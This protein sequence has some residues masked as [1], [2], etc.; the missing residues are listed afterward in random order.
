MPP[1]PP[2]HFDLDGFE[3][4]ADTGRSRLLRVRGRWGCPDERQLPEPTLLVHHGSRVARLT[5]LPIGGDAPPQ[6][7]P[8]PPGWAATYSVPK[9]IFAT[10]APLVYELQVVPDVYHP[11]PLPATEPAPSGPEEQRPERPGVTLAT[12]AGDVTVDVPQATVAGTLVAAGA[13]IIATAVAITLLRSLNTRPE[14]LPIMLVAIST[15]LIMLW[16][17]AWIVPAFAALTWTSIEQSQFG[18]VSPIEI[19]GLVLL[20]VA[21]L[22]GLRRPALLANAL[23]VCLFI[24]LPLLI[25]AL[26]SPDGFSMPTDA[27]KNLSFLLI[28][29]LGMQ[30]RKD[31]DRLTIALCLVAIF[32]GVGAASSVLLGPSGIF[33]VETDAAG[34]EAVRAAGPFGESNFFAL[35]LAA[36]LPVAI[37]NVSRVGW[38][39]SLGL[40][41]AAAILAGIFAAGSRGGFLT[42]GFAIA[43][44]GLAAG[45]REVRLGALAVLGVAFLMFPLF[46]AQVQSSAGRTVSGRE[47]ENLIAIAQFGDHPITGV[48]PDQYSV[49]YRDYSRKIGSDARVE[50]EAH[51]LPLQLAAEQG[52]VGLLGWIGAIV[53]VVRFAWGRGVWDSM[54]GR[55]MLI[56]CATWMFGSL[57]LHA[58]LLRLLFML[59]GAVLALA[60]ASGPVG[61]RAEDRRPAR[62]RAAEASG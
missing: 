38:R 43:A 31:I 57:F 54:L 25:S 50:R 62:G 49:L 32:L 11:L 60:G 42:A 20:G 16:N 27:L 52:V 33:P 4:V 41:A 9:A 17:S 18:G 61:R 29:A 23:F 48:G 45:R 53:A 1:T 56:S 8:Q 15:G 24:A 21:L 26:L 58:G 55:A 7:G 5:P 14:L 2:V 10:E 3:H 47:T 37:Y 19:G 44:F 28:V 35:S 51:S 59:V 46:G 12:T 22:R 13:A 34:V 36:L 6:A 40:A 39:R 30:T